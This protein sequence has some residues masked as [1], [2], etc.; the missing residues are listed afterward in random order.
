MYKELIVAAIETLKDRTGS[1]MQAIKKYTQANFPK[2]KTYQNSMFLKALT[3]GVAKGDFVKNKGS[4]KLSA[5]FKKKAAAAAKPKKAPV[6][7]KAPAKKTTTYVCLC[8]L[9]FLLSLHPNL[10]F[11]SS[12]LQDQEEDGAKEE[13]NHVSMHPSRSP[14]TH[15][16]CKRTI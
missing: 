14:R 13:D 7:K 6:K 11:H 5:D 8:L 16:S 4:Y 1:S 2:D 3:H 15:F 12:F 9:L 10:C